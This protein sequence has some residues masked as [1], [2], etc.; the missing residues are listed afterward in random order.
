MEDFIKLGFDRE[1]ISFTEYL[2][3]FYSDRTTTNRLLSHKLAHLIYSSSSIVHLAII[4]AIEE[5]GNVLFELIGKLAEQ[6]EEETGIELRYCGK[7][8]FSKES[9]HA[10]TCDHAI[11]AEIEMDEQT[12]AEAIEKV[13]LVFAYFTEWTEELL[14]YAKQ[15]LNHPYE[16]LMRDFKREMDLV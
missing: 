10:M 16:P 4:E 8:H 9:G 13:N 12:S 15:N 2:Q 7:F 5:T 3:F 6:I 14:V 11:M 1:K